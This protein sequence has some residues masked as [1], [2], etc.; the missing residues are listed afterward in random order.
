LLPPAAIAAAIL[1]GGTTDAFARSHQ[2]TVTTPR[3][4]YTTQGSS[5]CAA[6]TCSH[7]GSVTG[8]NGKSL[9]RSGSIT[10]TAPGEYSGTRTVT[11]P[12][13][14]SRTTTGSTTFTPPAQ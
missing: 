12:N 2:G 1:V 5:S 7:S 14:G 9:S 3:G 10:K 4:T 11:G 6:G 8:P 13:G